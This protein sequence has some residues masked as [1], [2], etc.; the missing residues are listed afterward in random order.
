MEGNRDRGGGNDKWGENAKLEGG[1]LDHQKSD[2]YRSS[3]IN[4]QN[5][6]TPMFK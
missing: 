4:S 6:N 3:F 2:I 5:K 1:V